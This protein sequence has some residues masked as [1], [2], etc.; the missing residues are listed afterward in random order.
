MLCDTYEP[1]STCLRLSEAERVGNYERKR[2][3]HTQGAEQGVSKRS[4]NGKTGLIDR[5]NE[6]GNNRSRAHVQS[7]VKNSQLKGIV[8]TI[9]IGIVG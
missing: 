5:V 3:A 7:R 6:K 9:L 8:G 1:Y 2:V 4:G